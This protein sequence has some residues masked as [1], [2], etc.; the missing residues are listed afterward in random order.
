M[1][2][3]TEDLFKDESLS[4]KL[5]KKW[6]WLYFFTL[7]I[8]PTWYIIRVLLSNDSNISVE[9]LWLIYSIISFISIISIYNDIWLTHSLKYFLPKFW[10]EKK[11]DEFKTSIFIT[12]WIQL[13]TWVLIAVL[14]FFWSDK[15]AINYFHTPEASELLKVFCLYFLW[16]NIYQV[17]DSIFL[18]FQDI[19]FKKLIEFIKFCSIMILTYIIFIVDKWSV[20]LY[21]W[22]WVAGLFIA[23]LFAIFLFFKK[24]WYI[25]KK[26]KIN[27]NKSILKTIF[28]Y[29]IW[30]FLSA[31]AWIILAQIDQQMIVYYLWTRE[32]GYYS[33]YLAILWLSAMI[34]S[35]MISLL[36]PIIRESLSKN[37]WKV[38]L[39]INFFYK[40]FSILSLS[41]WVLFVSLWP[42][43]SNIL[44]WAKFSKSWELLFYS[45]A[46]IFIWVLSSIN[47][48][49]LSA[50]GKIKY[51]T[52]I[53]SLVAVINFI[54]NYILINTIWIVWA[55][56]STIVWW[57]LMFILSFIFVYKDQ[58]IF[59]NWP[60]YI[61]N[62][63][64][65]SIIWSLLYKFNYL[66]FSFH[67]RI[68]DFIYL[69]LII[70][71]YFIFLWLVNYKEVVSLR[72][73]IY[74]FKK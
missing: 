34:I 70:L 24:Y 29:S 62:I 4:E 15:I 53:I 23:L 11:Y 46:F 30:I 54:L 40:Y 52:L 8:T 31:N 51:T 42:V 55:I 22:A 72:K 32:A 18:S 65:F 48:T 50:K 38:I 27:I 66:I 69:V 39:L 67:S 45:W 16:I 35:P 58:K 9:D 37:D 3:N 1:K 21:G 63:I 74:T 20:L 41:I 61:K 57:I 49:I 26:W 2:K 10:I 28:W 44:F 60:F 13:I 19:F 7:I 12:L 33:N 59:F 17:I 73:E 5:I 56:Y 25:F 14:L 6:S 71:L 36:F 68:N 64:Y 47:F 43:I